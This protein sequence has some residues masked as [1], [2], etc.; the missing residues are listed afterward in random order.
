M[1][2]PATY[3]EAATMP[4][5]D[6][7]DRYQALNDRDA[8]A[9]AIATLQARGR[10]SADR[11]LNPEDYPPLTAA[12]HLEMLA[13]GEAMARHYRHPAQVHHAVIAG[14]TWDQIAAATGASA[15]QA[16]QAYRAW[17]EGQHRLR[18]DFPGGTIGLDAGEY[19]AAI[20]AADA[21]TPGGA[22]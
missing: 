14:A 10:W 7:I 18:S 4:L 12:E 9:R 5:A 17:A 2:A 1:T 8:M 11:G 13:L 16:R 15:D 3:D 21:G 6:V 20:E 22:P 19:A